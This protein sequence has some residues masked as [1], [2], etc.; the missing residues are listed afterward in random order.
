MD[1]ASRVQHDNTNHRYR[2]DFPDLLDR[3]NLATLENESSS[4]FG[5]AADL[6][7][8]YFNPAWFQ[9]AAANGGEPA[10]STRFKL[11]TPVADAMDA[12][13]QSFYLDAYGYTLQSG[14]VWEHD[15][16]CSSADTF[17]L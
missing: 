15:Y 13:M 17:R 4:V 8:N 9:F 12:S 2:D 7:L 10:I 1:G 6:T 16:E 14:V 11:G 5:L 3:F